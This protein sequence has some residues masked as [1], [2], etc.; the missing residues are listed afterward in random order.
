[1]PAEMRTNKIFGV[2][3]DPPNSIE[4]LNLKL[5]YVT[6]TLS[7]HASFPLFRD[8]YDALKSYV[9][10]SC[11]T[12]PGA[13]WFGKVPISSWLTPRP[14]SEDLTFLNPAHTL[15]FLRD[16]GCWNHAQQVERYYDGQ[17]HPSRPVMIGV[18]H[19]TTGGMVSALAKQYSNLNVIVLDAHFD[20]MKFNGHGLSLR[21][22]EFEDEK[23]FYHCGNFLSYLL[24]GGIIKPENLWV[25]GVGKGMTPKRDHGI[26]G[27]SC[28]V[29]ELEQ[30]KWVN[31][32][33]HIVTGEMVSNGWAGPH[34]TG[35]TY[36]SIDMDIG[37]LSSVY[38]ARFMNCYGLGPQ[39][40]HTLLMTVR[41]AIAKAGTFL[42]GLDIM[43]IDIHFL[44]VAREMPNRDFTMEIVK[45]I[46]EIFLQE[47]TNYLGDSKGELLN[48]GV[49]WNRQ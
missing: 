20:V 39:E 34:L 26:K 15:S 40:F 3:F 16:N 19:S 24:E 18:D 30:R 48:G 14:I 10:D 29:N 46:F 5:A 36:L 8:P 2:P 49:K 17:V 27:E 4:R 44:E 25:I 11:F 23:P 13:S 47:K 37:S 38:S 1:M 9:R 35:P 6:R 43:E 7:E 31:R 22:P 32:G 42:V 28:T 33:V 45:R 41:D 21:V 12:T